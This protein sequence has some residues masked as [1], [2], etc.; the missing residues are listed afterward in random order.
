MS[1]AKTSS[2]DTTALVRAVREL[3]GLTQEQLAARLGVS[4]VTINRWENDRAKPMPLALRQIKALLIE[5]SQ[6]PIAANR[7]TA[8]RLLRQYFPDV[9]EKS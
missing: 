5:L 4:L 8:E 7:P 9:P 2:A 3:C 1:P 6:S